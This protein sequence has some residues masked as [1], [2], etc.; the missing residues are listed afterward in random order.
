MLPNTPTNRS[1]LVFSLTISS[2]L[3]FRSGCALYK[4]AWTASWCVSCLSRG[5]DDDDESW[6][7]VH[8]VIVFI[9][10]SC[11]YFLSNGFH[12]NS[13]WGGNLLRNKHER[14][15]QLKNAG[16]LLSN[17]PRYPL[18]PLKS[19]RAEYDRTITETE[20]AF[21]RV[22]AV[23]NK[24]F[25]V[26]FNS[27]SV[28]RTCCTIHSRNTR[29]YTIC[30]FSP[31][32]TNSHTTKHI[33]TR[34]WRARRRCCKCWSAKRR[35]CPPMHR[36]AQ[37][38]QATARACGKNKMEKGLGKGNWGFNSLKRMLCEADVANVRPIA[39]LP[40]WFYKWLQYFHVPSLFNLHLLFNFLIQ[41][42]RSSEKGLVWE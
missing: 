10:A 13:S 28:Q 22:S 4:R 1:H 26:A 27:S 12:R 15:K 16:K 42:E 33:N 7:V 40:W 37:A 20:Q 8:R 31:A 6:C 38:V 39:Y 25:S 18:Y 35:H 11:W 9:L 14:F 41:N 17:Q 30:T 32:P 21:M 3:F 34:L 5:V 24:F 36:R 29:T 23:L 2:S 19:A